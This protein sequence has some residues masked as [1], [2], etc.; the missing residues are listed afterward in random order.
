MSRFCFSCILILIKLSFVYSSVELNTARIAYYNERDYERAK[1][2]CLNGIKKGEIN[3]ELQGIL[4]GCEIGLG[5]W[6][7]AANA[8]VQA[9]SIDSLKTHEWMKKRGGESYYYQGFFF[10]AREFYDEELFDKALTALEYAMTL[11]PKDTAPLILKGVILYKLGKKSE[12]NEIYHKA[13]DLDPDNPDINY[14]IGKS[15]F[16]AKE[17]E[18][19]IIYFNNAVKSYR[20]SFNCAS[21]VLFSNAADS[22]KTLRHKVNSLWSE[23]KYDELD[24]VLRDSLG[25][26][27]GID[28]HKINIE[29]FY[30]ATDD[31]ARS[32]YYA[33]MAYYYLKND[34]MALYHLI[35][36][37]VLKPDDIDALFFAGEILVNSQAYKE[38]VAYF[39]RATQIKDDDMYAW[40]YL[41]VSYMKLKKYR[42]AIKAFEDKVLSIDPAHIHSMQNLAF[43][44]REI[45]DNQKSFEYLKQVDQI[46]E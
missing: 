21:L 8:L 6:K 24:H 46:N 11:K 30:K 22:S 45:G 12:A 31:L 43:L 13:L 16:E 4:G 34:S 23:K 29:K 3:F 44:Y 35:K 15:L 37:I 26:D 33:G 28:A 32:N 19:S 39:E 18:G 5:N 27:G 7:K 40:F 41:G 10:A 36:T 9:F 1:V 14:L 42:K 38:A 2:A 20:L 25:F 17:F